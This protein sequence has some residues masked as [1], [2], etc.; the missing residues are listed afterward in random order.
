[1][2]GDDELRVH[3]LR[4]EAISRVADAG[5][6]TAAEERRAVDHERPDQHAAR[7]TTRIGRGLRARGAAVRRGAVPSARRCLSSRTGKPRAPQVPSS[8]FQC[9]T[10]SSSRSSLISMLTIVRQHGLN[11]ADLG[12]GARQPTAPLA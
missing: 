5:G 8:L 7:T 4:H 1:M 10:A 11:V 9:T 12:R 3:D 2:A 6:T